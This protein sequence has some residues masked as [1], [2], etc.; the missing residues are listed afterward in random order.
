MNFAAVTV[1]RKTAET[2][3]QVVL[4][5]RTGPVA[6][7][8]LPNRLLAHFIDHFTRAS[9]VMV[10][11]AGTDWPGSY[12]FDHV[13]CE[14]LGQLLGRG[15]AAIHDR[16]AAETGVPGR[17]SATC[18]MD[19]AESEVVLTFEGRPSA[20]WTVPE[21]I[22]IDGFVDSWYD[23]SGR[24]EGSGQGTNLRQFLD[25]FAIGAGAGL[26][27]TVRRSG[28]LHHL[29]ETIFRGLGDAVAVAIG[30]AGSCLPG[31]TSGLAGR[32]DY[33]VEVQRS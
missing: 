6:T 28:N 33:T 31:E 27:V 13:L 30:T 10:E 12:R 26:S 5:S 24:M 22:D 19:D 1:T 29:Y 8:D 17:G 15:I 25:G 11:S 16:K 21:G 2:G 23:A 20:T 7:L 14:D 9:G 3:F 4:R 32:C 18:V